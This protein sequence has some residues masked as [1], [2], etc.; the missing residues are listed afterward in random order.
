[1]SIY[2]SGALSYEINRYTSFLGN[3]KSSCSGCSV[4]EIQTDQLILGAI[5]K[6][7]FKVSRWPY[8]DGDTIKIVAEDDIW[9]KESAKPCQY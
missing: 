8:S 3:T 6:D 5:I 7:T 1:M 9:I 2:C 4:N